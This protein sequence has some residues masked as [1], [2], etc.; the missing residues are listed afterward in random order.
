MKKRIHCSVVY[1]IRAIC[2]SFV[3]YGFR[4]GD[5]T[6][7][8]PDEP[9]PDTNVLPARCSTARKET[10]VSNIGTSMAWPSPERSLSY[11]AIGIAYAAVRPTTLSTRIVLTYRGP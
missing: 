11:K 9:S 8:Y 7:G 10:M 3:A 1:G 5:M 4:C 6:R 2:P